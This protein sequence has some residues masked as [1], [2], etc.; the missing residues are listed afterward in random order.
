MLKYGELPV[1]RSITKECEVWKAMQVPLSVHTHVP[2]PNTNPPK[3][4]C[5]VSPDRQLMRFL[6]GL[7]SIGGL[8]TN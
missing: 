2:T 3:T 6:E 7:P 1:L 8:A 5:P 4:K